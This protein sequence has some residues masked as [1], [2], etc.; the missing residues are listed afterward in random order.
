MNRIVKY[1]SILIAANYGVT[2]NISSHSVINSSQKA[3]DPCLRTTL[4]LFYGVVIERK[5]GMSKEVASNFGFA[6]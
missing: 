4:F 1:S 5:A 2:G 6:I 3:V